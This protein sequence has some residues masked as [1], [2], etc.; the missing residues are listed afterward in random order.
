[1]TAKK[2]HL[3]RIFDGYGAVNNALACARWAREMGLRESQ[4]EIRRTGPAS[5]YVQEYGVYTTDAGKAKMAKKLREL[6]VVK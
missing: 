2:K 5:N 6:G 4:I 3:V 1:M